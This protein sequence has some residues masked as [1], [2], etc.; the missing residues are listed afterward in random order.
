ML[1]KTAIFCQ[2]SELQL[3]EVLKIGKTKRY[4]KG[5][6]IFS[7]GQAAEGAYVII[8]GK[9]KVYKL[10]SDG[11]QYI[12]HIFGPGEIFAESA[13]FSGKTYP[14]F[15]QA[16]E[17][18]RL[19]YLSKIDFIDLIQKNSSMAINMLA[20]QAA[21][22]RQFASKIE[23]LSL[24]E[25]SARLAGYIIEQAEISG[26]KIDKGLELKLPM[27]KSQLASYLGTISETL[28]RTLASFKNKGFIVEE[29]N[30]LIIKNLEKLR[31]IAKL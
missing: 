8:E 17:N 14:A 19:F 26:R 30:R 2:L 28:S 7:Q 25:V 21:R 11:R 5:A 20:S 31:F 9:V 10:G 18:C 6:T 13:M 15:A 24:K 22:L 29:N 16:V 27:N 4:A 1:K 23:D 12:L 3:A